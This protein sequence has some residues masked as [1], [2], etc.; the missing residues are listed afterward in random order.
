MATDRRRI[1]GPP[2]GT[3]QPVLVNELSLTP[4]RRIRGPNELRKICERSSMRLTAS[5][6]WTGRTNGMLEL[7]LKTGLTPSA[8]GSA[9]LELEPPPPASKN[10]LA[11]KVSSLKLTCT[12]HGPRP[13]PRSAPFSSQLLLSTR[14]KFAPFASWE[15]KGYVPDASE[16]DLAAHLESA[17]RGVIIGER[18]PKS[19][20]D[21]VVT[22][23]EGEE[24]HSIT[25]ASVKS[26][27]I[28]SEWAIMFVL[29]GCITAASAA[30][31]DAGIDCVD[32]VTGGVAAIIQHTSLASQIV[33]DPCLSDGEEIV[34]ACVVG[35]LHSRDEV[36]ELLFK[37]NLPQSYSKHSNS[38][39]FELLVDHA[40]Q[41][42]IAARSVSIDAIKEG[43]EAKIQVD[44]GDTA[45]TTLKEWL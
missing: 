9:Y 39:G 13:L 40:V 45:K 18:W 27:S 8:S 22:I 10:I 12:V 38:L 1:R 11:S 43:V 24:D 17:L 36:T 42:A 15:R 25:E 31:V 23:L 5:M 35:Y 2:G 37:G 33:L 41:A 20:T 30:L 7:D 16:R 6:S 34:T 3:S 28:H 19:G 29:S 26:R 21:I 14:V 32:L 4:P 44:E